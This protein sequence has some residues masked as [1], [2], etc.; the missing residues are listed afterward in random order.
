M[1]LG[2]G[3]TP[4]RALCGPCRGS[5][6]G[7]AAS[8]LAAFLT[9]LHTDADADAPVNP[10]RGVPLAKRADA[11]IPRIRLAAGEWALDLA[12]VFS[13]NSGNQ[14]ALASIARHG[15]TETLADPEFSATG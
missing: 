5:R 4:G 2:G 11:W 7:P 9:A 12:T 1:A 3:A 10:F 14:P 15:L 8:G 6:S 13:Q